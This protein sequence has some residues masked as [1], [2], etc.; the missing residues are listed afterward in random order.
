MAI[1]YVAEQRWGIETKFLLIGTDS[2]L[3]RT[4]KKI[5]NIFYNL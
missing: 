3:K 2:Y 1:K 4:S 5:M